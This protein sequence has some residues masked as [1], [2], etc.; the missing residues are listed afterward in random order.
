[1][2]WFAPDK[3]RYRVGDF[4][5]CCVG[6]EN[7]ER[8][9]ATGRIV[10]LLYRES[11][12]PADRV[13]PYQIKLDRESAMRQGVPLNQALIYS[14]RDDDNQIRRIPPK[15]SQRKAASKSGGKKGRRNR[16]QLVD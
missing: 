16:M 10:K 8:L 7:G 9:Y 13:A 11:S 14:D 1:M 15:K 3:L 5:E 2:K 12:W 4:V 6:E